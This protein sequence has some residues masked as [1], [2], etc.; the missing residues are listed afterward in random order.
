MVFDG[1]GK[2]AYVAGKT[3]GVSAYTLDLN[4]GSLAQLA[5]S[6]FPAGTAPI[7]VVTT[8]KIQ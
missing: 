3:N 2:Y 4:T 1:S 7:W 6:P 8:S 5:V